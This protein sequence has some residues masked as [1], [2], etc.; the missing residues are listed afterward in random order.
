MRPDPPAV[1]LPGSAD[2]LL[3]LSIDRH[4]VYHTK[5]HISRILIARTFRLAAWL[6]FELLSIDNVQLTAIP[7]GTVSRAR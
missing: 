1:P 5:C 3:A 2:S 4:D 6:C 7:L